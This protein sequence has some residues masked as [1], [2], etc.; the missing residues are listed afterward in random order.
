MRNLLKNLA[1][2]GVTLGLAL[3][4]GE[5]VARA[6]FHDITTT[7]DN[8]SYF[9]LRWKQANVRLNRYGF[10]E[11]EFPTQKAPGAYRV[12]FIGDSYTFGQ[13]IAESERM[14]NLL[15]ADLREEAP[16]VEVLNFGN[17]G[18]NTADE[19]VVL[20]KVLGELDPDFVVLQW[21]VNDV[22]YKGPRV[23]GPQPLQARPSRI[24]RLRRWLRNSSVLYFLAGEVAH[25]IQ[26]TMG[27]TYEAELSRHVVDDQSVEWRAH[28]EALR[29]FIRACRDRNIGVAV[30][31]VPSAMPT[32]GAP[33]PLS[34]LHDRVLEVCGREG[35]LCTDLLTI[36]K[37]Y[38]DDATR[39][40]QLWVNRFDPHMGR[41][42][43]Q[44]A[45]QQLM[46][47]VAPSVLVEA[48]SLGA[49]T[50]RSEDGHGHGRD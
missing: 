22:E 28:D 50:P 5:L 16:N 42:A 4:A 21:F 1:V 14:S 34:F 40:Q 6:V 20:Q 32:A 18:N 35:A 25:R 23:N 37:P 17:A 39:Y 9:A 10:R 36:F 27:P 48:A 30:V 41:L 44:I 47:V 49:P 7:A 8:G 2:L 45:A 13:G 12:A 38:M 3:P 11:R 46:K 31:L 19:V 43:N 24:I 29:T 33:Y 26:E 15:E